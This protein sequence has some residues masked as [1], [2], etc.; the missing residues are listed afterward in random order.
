ML[1]R[2]KEATRYVLDRADGPAVVERDPASG[3]VI[4]EE[5]Y[6]D[7]KQVTLP[8]ARPHLHKMTLRPHPV[9]AAG[10]DP[11]LVARLSGKAA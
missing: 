3:S 7:G 2:A 9:L 6:K 4:N 5:W 11:R 8:R 10:A 1:E